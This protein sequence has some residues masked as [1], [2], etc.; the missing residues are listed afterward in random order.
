MKLSTPRIP[1]YLSDAVL[2]ILPDGELYEV[3]LTDQDATKM[4]VPALLIDSVVIE[5]CSFLQA[6]LL[7]VGAKDLQVK[8]SDFSS[9]ALIDGSLN[10][11]EFSNCRMSGVDFSKATLHDVTFRGCK[12]DLANFR[13]TDIRRV[14]FIDCTLV[15]TDFLGATLHDVGFQT[16][17]LEK[18]IFERAKCSLVDMRSSE[19][20]EIS[21]WGSMKGVILDSL[22]LVGVAPYL[23]RELGLNIK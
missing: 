17:T 3:R 6:Q 20:Q 23:A 2:D 22:Q 4:N 11:V 13:F 10:R 18:T 9:A 8:Q 14:R 21:G 15:E 16:C 7:R 19:L 1:A 5:K 12:L